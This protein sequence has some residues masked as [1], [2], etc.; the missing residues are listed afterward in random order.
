MV[1]LRRLAFSDDFSKGVITYYPYLL[2]SKLL[3]EFVIGISKLGFEVLGYGSGLFVAVGGH[4]SCKMD[5]NVA[6]KEGH[7]HE[8]HKIVNRDESKRA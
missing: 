8:S 4:L 7:G 3:P 1:G 6:I 5:S 2:G